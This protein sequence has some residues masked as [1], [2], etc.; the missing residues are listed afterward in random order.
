M[1]CICIQ[2]WIHFWISMYQRHWCPMNM[3]DRQAVLKKFKKKSINNWR[4]MEHFSL[5]KR[6]IN[7]LMKNCVRENRN[8]KVISLESMAILSNWISIDFFLLFLVWTKNGSD[9]QFNFFSFGYIHMH[10]WWELCIKKR[11]WRTSCHV[12]LL[13]DFFSCIINLLEMK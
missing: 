1:L 8:R 5:T 13:L 7:V 3:V 12:F 2:R 10:C 11:G 9:H 6:P 4:K